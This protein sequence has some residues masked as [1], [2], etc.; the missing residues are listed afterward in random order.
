MLSLSDKTEKI[1]PPLLLEPI[2]N[3]APF[4]DVITKRFAQTVGVCDARVQL[5]LELPLTDKPVKLSC[6]MKL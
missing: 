6:A 2:K 4:Q 5:V 1:D 3:Q